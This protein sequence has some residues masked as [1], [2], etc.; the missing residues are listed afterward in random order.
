MEPDA[1]QRGEPKARVLI[2][3]DAEAMSATAAA[4]LARAIAGARAQ[5]GVAQVA[6]SGGTTPVRAYELLAGEIEDWRE[7]ELWFADERCV[8]PE[9]PES[10]YRLLAETLLAGASAPDGRR[11]IADA[12]VHRMEGELGPKRGAERYA[13]LLRA[14]VRADDDGVPALDVVVLGIGPEGHIASLFPNSRAL[15]DA[16]ALCLGVTDSPKPPP[17][18]ITLGLAVLR[19]ARCA[20]L[21]ASGEGK[22][23]ALGAALADPSAA[24]PASLMPR[25]RL[26]VVADQAA[27]AALAVAAER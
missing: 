25:D 3:R 8:G 27:A 16:D 17:R 23:P 11:L 12:Q 20:L 22:A 13:E 9:D 10:N 4:E 14:R 1:P 7:V 15:A 19:A 24:A 6:L 18:R 26:T 21:L 2:G 5:R